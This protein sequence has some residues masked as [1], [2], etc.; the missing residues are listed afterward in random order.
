MSRA[1]DRSEGRQ[2]GAQAPEQ[3]T[4]VPG[5]GTTTGAAATGTASSTTSGLPDQPTMQ[6]SRTQQSGM[7]QS[8]TQQPGAH[9][10]TTV[11][12][13]STDY[14]T[15][16]YQYGQDTGAGATGGA[17]AILAGL[18]TFLA[19]L[20]AVVRRNFY[21]V[22]TNYAYNIHAYD[23]GWILLAIGVVLFALGACALL[24]MAWARYLGVGVAV[25]STVAGFLFL[26]YSPIWGIVLVA[27]SV[28]AI[29][30]LLHDSDS[31]AR[32]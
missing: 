3:V 2:P 16:G 28:I 4:G 12:A 8:G 1:Q 13:R 19:G 22:N 17:F 9:R 7:Q 27:V 14:R 30:G 31:S 25:L 15:T 29:W 21:H 23:W 26:P 20:S 24:G 32:I 18:I 5:T 10:Q 11:Q 6:Q